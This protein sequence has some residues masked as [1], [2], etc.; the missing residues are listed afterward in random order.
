MGM[1]GELA[2]VGIGDADVA[3]FA[4]FGAII[5]A[6]HAKAD[7]LL[8]LAEAAVF[9]AGAFL[10]RLVAQGTEGYHAHRLSAASRFRAKRR[11][12]GSS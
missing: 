2:A 5:E 4:T 8:G 3:G 10:L 9:L 12:L 11:V 6:I 1:S 7:I